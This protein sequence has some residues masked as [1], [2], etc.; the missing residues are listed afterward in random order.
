MCKLAGPRAQAPARGNGHLT[1]G[2]LLGLPVGTVGP[3]LGLKLW[4][5]VV[6]CKA[7]MSN[8]A[9]N[10]STLNYRLAMRQKEN[11]RICRFGN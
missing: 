1:L 4:P 6:L 2:G 11:T 8:R 5:G 9:P 10:L 7:A 3:D